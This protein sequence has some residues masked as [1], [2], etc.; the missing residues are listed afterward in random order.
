MDNNKKGGLLLAALVFLI[1]ANLIIWGYYLLHRMGDGGEVI[2]LWDS[3]DLFLDPGEDFNSLLPEPFY[4]E[5][6]EQE[7]FRLRREE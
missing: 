5:P 4:G 1:I 7:G 6:D 2:Q 3:E